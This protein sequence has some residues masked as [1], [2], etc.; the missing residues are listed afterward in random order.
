MFQK[1]KDV[2]MTIGSSLIQ[3]SK[4]LYHGFINKVRDTAR[5]AKD[6]VR[7]ALNKVSAF[8]AVG[9]LG[10]ALSTNASADVPAG[11]TTAITTAATDVATVGAAVILVFVGIKVWKW[12][13]QAL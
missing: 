5:K 6:S 13:K 10:L 1:S 9:V 11:V 8:V 4:A 3:T 12:L 2:V 7:R